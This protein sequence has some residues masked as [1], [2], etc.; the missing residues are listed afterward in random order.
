VRIQCSAGFF[1][2]RPER[3]SMICA[4]IGGPPDEIV[5]LKYIE[6]VRSGETGAWHEKIP[7]AYRAEIAAATS[8]TISP[9]TWAM[10][11]LI[12]FANASGDCSASGSAALYRF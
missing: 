6:E 7:A 2:L 9:D 8:A 12:P 3:F 11:A 5:Q 4:V 10:A 1:V